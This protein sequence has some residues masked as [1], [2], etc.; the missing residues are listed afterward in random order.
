[1]QERLVEIAEVLRRYP[2]MM[3]VMKQTNILNLYV[4][5]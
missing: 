2:W 1:M 5:G 3:G 4:V